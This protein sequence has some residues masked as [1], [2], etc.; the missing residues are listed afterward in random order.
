MKANSTSEVIGWGL[1]GVVALGAIYAFS[2]QNNGINGTQLYDKN[3]NPV[4]NPVP[5]VYYDAAG[6]PIVVRANPVVIST[7]SIFGDFSSFLNGFSV[8]T[9]PVPQGAYTGPSVC[10]RWNPNVLDTLTGQKGVWCFYDVNGNQVGTCLPDLQYIDTNKFP[11][12]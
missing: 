12:C 9:S 3:G 4:S 7:P 11:F 10:I 1:L 2:K 6:N 8:G 5:G